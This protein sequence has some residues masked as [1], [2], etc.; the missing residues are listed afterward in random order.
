MSEFFSPAEIRDLTAAKPVGRQEA[1][2]KEKGIP[3]QRDGQRLIVL[4]IHIR[5]WV[6]GRPVVSSGGLNWSTVG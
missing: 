3:Y 1:W 2:L 4:R 6:E 5:A